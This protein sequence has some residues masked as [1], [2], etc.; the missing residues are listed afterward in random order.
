M[1]ER[2]SMSKTAAALMP[3][4]GRHAFLRPPTA[5]DLALALRYASEQNAAH[6]S[7]EA[8][9]VPR[10]GGQERR[11]DRRFS[12]QLPVI[13][14]AGERMGFG[15]TRDVSLGGLF[16]ETDS[17]CTFGEQI[18]VKFRAAGLQQPLSAPAVVRWVE[19][20][21]GMGV[22]FGSVRPLVIWALQQEL[23]ELKEG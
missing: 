3:A 13:F 18:T 20:G 19:P 5:S 14:K 16:I 22:Q 6:G 1:K 10:A 2:K 7:S 23:K 21:H 9:L 8:P 15:S 12:V 11:R 17:P 4:P